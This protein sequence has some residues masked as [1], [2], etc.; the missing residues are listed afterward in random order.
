[1]TLIKACIVDDETLAIAAIRVDLSRHCPSVEVQAEFKS[2]AQ[3]L[4]FLKTSTIDLLFLD[5]EMPEMT[6]LELLDKLGNFNFDV[7]FTTAYSEYALQAFKLNAIDY[8][9]KPVDTQELVNTVNRVIEKKKLTANIPK[10]FKIALADANSLEFV[11]MDNIM[12]CIADKNYTTFYLQNGSKKLVSKNIGEYEKILDNS[13]FIRIHQ[14]SIVNVNYVSKLIKGENGAA[15]MEDG[16][17][18]SVSRA[19]RKDFLAELQKIA[20]Q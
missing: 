10:P 4:E 13:K 18:L 6:G 2:P 12:Y 16:C 19:K 20:T 17:E 15:V 7:V 11:A 14:S 3:A 8:L 5:I 9:L 1:M